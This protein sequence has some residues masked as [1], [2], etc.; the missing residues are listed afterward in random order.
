MGVTRVLSGVALLS[1][2]LSLSSCVAQKADLDRFQKEFDSRIIKL[3]QEKKALENSVAQTKKE[4]QRILEQQRRELTELTKA[5]AQIKSEV[6]NLR[7]ENLARISG[8]VETEAYRIDQVNRRLDDMNVE[9][10]GIRQLIH[11]R[12]QARET[13]VTALAT[14]LDQRF[15]EQNQTIK[16]QLQE[17]QGS[18]MGFKEAL[19]GVKESVELEEQRA[20]QTTK[21]L[22]SRMDSTGAATTTQFEKVNESLTSVTQALEK[23]TASLNSR[24]DSEGTQLDELRS[25]VNANSQQMKED[26]QLANTQLQEMTQ[27]ISQL[28]TA[29]DTTG[30]TMGQQVDA[31]G[32]QVADMANQL[33]LLEEKSQT[34]QTQIQGQEQQSQEMTASVSQLRDAL[35]MTGATLGT[36]ADQQIQQVRDAQSQILQLDSSIQKF[37]VDLESQGTQ[38]QGLDQRLTVEEQEVLQLTKT[39]QHIRDTVDTV[40]EMLGKR[41]DNQIQQVGQLIERLNRLEQDQANIIAKQEANVSATSAHLLE[42]NS[43]VQS[44]VNALQAMKTNVTAQLAEQ[45]RRIGTTAMP[46]EALQQLEQELVSNVGHLNELTKTVAQLREVVNTIGT[47]MGKRVDRHG[48]ALSKISGELDQLTRKNT[49]GKR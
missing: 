34:I 35:A 7:E 3:D 31:Q 41:G 45:D 33:L 4:S 12:D 11:E 20:L 36:Q 47:K 9:L 49:Q 17:F 24:I 13:Q 2:A 26:V 40:G 44:V 25:E 28:R 16:N 18:L 42:V 23:T 6:R 29:L 21:E 22:S 5:R 46:Q 1:V 37:N 10:D 38:L 15:V 39:T 27:S 32:Q 8:D 43:S 19:A 48:E 14:T 30:T